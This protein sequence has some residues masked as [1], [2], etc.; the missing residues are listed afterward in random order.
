LPEPHGWAMAGRIARLGRGTD[1]ACDDGSLREAGGVRSDG[2]PDRT[3]CDGACREACE[4][5]GSR[6]SL[7]RIHT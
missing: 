4:Q 3:E 5:S 2:N 1:K 7:T 6:T